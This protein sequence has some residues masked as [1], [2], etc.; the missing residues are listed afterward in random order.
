MTRAEMLA[1]AVAHFAGEYGGL[2]DG[3]NVTYLQARAD[4]LG[5]FLLA[6]QGRHG[7]WLTDHATLGTAAAAAIDA[8]YP[9]DWTPIGV[10]D[11]DNG[12]L[13]AAQVRCTLKMTGESLTV[14]PDDDEDD[15][16]LSRAQVAALHAELLANGGRMG[17]ALEKIRSAA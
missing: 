7:V 5:R 3:G 15:D 12:D 4:T 2:H 1:A 17:P 10:A 8:E 6:E 13:W 9:E 11:L 16:V 14:D